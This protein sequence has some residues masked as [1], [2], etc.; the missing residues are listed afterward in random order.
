MNEL[1]QEIEEKDNT[2]IKDKAVVLEEF[3]VE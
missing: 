2:Y 1:L 3:E